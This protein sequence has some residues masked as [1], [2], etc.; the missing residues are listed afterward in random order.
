M[1]TP[2]GDIPIVE[3]ED[4]RAKS[5]DGRVYSDFPSTFRSMATG[6]CGS[7]DGSIWSGP[8]TLASQCLIVDSGSHCTWENPFTRKLVHG[9]ENSNLALDYVV[10]LGKTTKGVRASMKAS[11]SFESVER[12]WYTIDLYL[13]SQSNLARLRPSVTVIRHLQ[14]S[15]GRCRLNLI[16]ILEV[17]KA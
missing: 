6:L 2:A 4:R 12:F 8:A 1:L 16:F 9:V 15:V 3:P 17:L 13:L 5:R 11:T 10:Q 7:R 14:T